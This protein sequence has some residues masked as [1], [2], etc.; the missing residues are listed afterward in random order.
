M[1]P[2]FVDSIARIVAPLHVERYGTPP[3][4]WAGNELCV[5]EKRALGID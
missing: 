5:Y 3:G 4:L 2:Y 1:D